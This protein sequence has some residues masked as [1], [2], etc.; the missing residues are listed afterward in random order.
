MNTNGGSTLPKPFIFV[1]MPFDT[2]F[3]DI[4][5]FGIQGAANEVGAYAERLDEQ[6]FTEGML[7]RIFNQISKA[8]VIVADMTGRSPNVFYEVG[9][10]HALGKIVLLLTQKTE[11]IPFDLKHRQH[12]VYSGS[13]DTLK[14][15]LVTKLQ[16][17]I[18]ESRKK[19]ELGISEHFSIRLFNT[20]IPRSGTTEEIP[21]ITGTAQATDFVIPMQVR[22]DSLETTSGIS[23]V[24]LF[25]EADT[26]VIPCE[27]ERHTSFLD[28]WN[29]TSFDL[30]SLSTSTTREPTARPLDS[31]VAN[32]IDAPDGL[33]KQFR[34]KITFP[35][36][37]PGAVEVSNMHLM[38]TEQTRETD[39]MY[40]IRL[41]SETQYHDFPYRFKVK[42][43]AK[44]TPEKK[45]ASKNYVK[46]KKKTNKS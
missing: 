8:D 35:A 11:D 3:D 46:K 43:K 21:E 1:L 6:I 13:I 5:K 31:F 29:T 37:P 27:Y 32:P 39:S 45:T 41:H 26:R 4:Y 40:R 44:S 42:Y 36:L 23:H 2:S 10:A 38:F 9:Y 34:L 22:N 24:Y 16:W 18:G 7:D 12:T 20:I 17:A 15:E 14:S 33:S 25:C 30:G 19:L 28:S